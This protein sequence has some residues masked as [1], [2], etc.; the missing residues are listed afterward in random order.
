MEVLLGKSPT[1]GPFSIAMLVITRGYLLKAYNMDFEHQVRTFYPLVMTNIAMDND[2]F[3]I[4]F[5]SYKPP[6]LGDFPWL[7]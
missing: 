2:P 3:I 7:C 5:P 6:F 4:D 1:N